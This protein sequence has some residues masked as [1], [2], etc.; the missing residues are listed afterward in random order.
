MTNYTKKK[1]FNDKY[2]NENSKNQYFYNV[3][4]KFFEICKKCD[5]FKKNSNSIIYFIHTFVIAE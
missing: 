4:M 3:I 5:I 2:N 1:N